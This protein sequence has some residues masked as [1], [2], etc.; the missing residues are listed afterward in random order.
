MLQKALHDRE[1]TRLGILTSDGFLTV[2]TLHCDHKEVT[3]NPSPYIPF[4]RA[5]NAPGIF[6]YQSEYL[7]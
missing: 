1:S 3:L 5:E 7:S 2:F 6:K 4:C